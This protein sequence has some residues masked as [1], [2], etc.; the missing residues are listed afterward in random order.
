MNAPNENPL[1]TAYV[2][3]ECAAQEAAAFELEM[4]QNADLAAE[5]ADFQNFSAFLKGNLG[6]ERLTLGAERIAQI[7]KSAQRPDNELI[8]LSNHRRSRWQTVGVILASA[9]VV[10]LGFFVL[11]ET[12]VSGDTLAKNQAGIGSGETNVVAQSGNGQPAPQADRPIP[13]Q[14]GTSSVANLENILVNERRL[15]K[16]GELSLSEL[17]AYPDYKISPQIQAGE[18]GVMTELGVCPW[19]SEAVLLGIW[20]EAQ[21]SHLMTLEINFNSKTVKSSQLL[22]VV[23]NRE[24]KII[25]AQNFQGQ[26]CFLYEIVLKNPAASENLFGLTLTVANESGSADEAFL[27]SSEISSS[28]ENGSLA[29]RTAAVLASFEKTFRSEN[30]HSPR[31]QIVSERATNLAQEWDDARARYVLDLVALAGEIETR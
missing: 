17:V 7:R 13:L 8:L 22:G 25:D 20:V 6:S 27:P 5:V 16:A 26:H 29:W 24:S 31:L 19:R 12:S 11:K 1:V 23:E 10:T 28:W 15:P 14:V 9:A 2:L 4:S 30:A 21:E 18:V 3:G